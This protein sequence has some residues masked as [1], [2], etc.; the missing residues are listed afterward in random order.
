MNISFIFMHRTLYKHLVLILTRWC[1]V[2]GVV[3]EWKS[4][5][6]FFYNSTPHHT[7]SYVTVYDTHKSGMSSGMSLETTCTSFH[8]L[9]SYNLLYSCET[10][11]YVMVYIT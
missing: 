3:A 6:T 10:Y 1:I 11:S 9:S 8:S 5:S 7:A 4:N 2:H